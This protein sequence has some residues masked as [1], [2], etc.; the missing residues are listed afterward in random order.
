M[1]LRD[2][3]WGAWLALFRIQSVPVSVMT[4][5]LGY[6]TVKHTVLDP[7]LIPLLAVT[8]F[9]HISVYAHN[10]IMDLKYDK[11]QGKHH[12]PLVAGDV[13]KDMAIIITILLGLLS[14][15]LAGM[16]MAD[17]P[18][19]LALYISAFAFGARYNQIST[20]YRYSAVYLGLWGLT[21]PLVG[22]FYAGGVNGY[23]I[24]LSLFV[25]L[26][27]F[28]MTIEGDLKDIN[29]GEDSIPEYL[30]C[31][32]AWKHI[33]EQ[34]GKISYLWTSLRFALFSMFILFLH[35]LILQ[36]FA[37]VYYF[38][39]AGFINHALFF[40]GTL[41]AGTAVYISGDRILHQEPFSRD[42]IKQDIVK[43]TVTVALAV[44]YVSTAFVN[45]ISI[46]ML[47]FGSIVWGLGWQYIQYGS[48]L[49]FP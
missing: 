4:V 10:D 12:K 27:M 22:S 40:I 35:F 6:A 24:L 23:T 19:A 34:D 33:D 49:Y 32:I 3:C 39:G 25:G 2:T 29:R 48:P 14:L 16:F 42:S 47:I 9:G 8:F 30:D 44:I 36:F 45:F 1:R 20:E 26:H 38:S 7:N 41:I 28:W 18:I 5:A 31:K 37:L 46:N 43:H 13:D 17:K 15:I 11:L 21:V